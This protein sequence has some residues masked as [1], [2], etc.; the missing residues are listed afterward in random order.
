MPSCM[1][2][3][4]V[5]ADARVQAQVFADAGRG[6]LAD[7][8][9]DRAVRVVQ[10]AEHDRLL[11]AGLGAGRLLAAVDAVHAH[12]AALDAALAAWHLGLLRRERLVHEAARLVRAGHHA[13]AAAD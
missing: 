13:V 11:R 9:R 6:D 10:V 2:S 4:S 3:D 12:R 7:A 5:I 8:L 1:S